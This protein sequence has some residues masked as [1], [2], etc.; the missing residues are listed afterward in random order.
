MSAWLLHAKDSILAIIKA[1]PAATVY[2]EL[3]MSHML[4][5]ILHLIYLE[6]MMS[7]R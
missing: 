3:C 5:Q 7:P 1:M 6:R 4:S 2:E